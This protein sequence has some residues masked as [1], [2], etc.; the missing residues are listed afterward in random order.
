MFMKICV[1][2]WMFCMWGH[3]GTKYPVLLYSFPDTEETSRDAAFMCSV[4]AGKGLE[5]CGEGRAS[6]FSQPI[7]GRWLATA[8]C[9]RIDMAIVNLFLRACSLLPGSSTHRVL[10]GSLTHITCYMS[11]CSRLDNI[12]YKISNYR[13]SVDS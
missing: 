11:E 9:C 2:K 5:H 1:Q 10:K 7:W 12:S 13:L 4:P 6:P 3:R 8:K